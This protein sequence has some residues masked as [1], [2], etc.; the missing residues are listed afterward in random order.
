MD[1]EQITVLLSEV[2]NNIGVF[3]ISVC[4]PNERIFMKYFVRGCYRKMIL[5]RNEGKKNIVR[6]KGGERNR[7]KNKKKIKDGRERETIYVKKNQK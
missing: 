7:I 6:N 5:K 2:S 1:L 4:C 3:H